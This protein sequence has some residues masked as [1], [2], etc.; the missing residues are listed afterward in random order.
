VRISVST[1]AGQYEANMRA[2]GAELTRSVRATMREVR[3]VAMERARWWSDG[4]YEQWQLTRKGHPYARRN[5][6]VV[7][8]YSQKT[9]RLS[10]RMK[11]AGRIGT[12][13]PARINYQSGDFYAGWRFHQRFTANE[14]TGSL[15]NVSPHARYLTGRPVGHM[16]GRPVMKAI[17]KDVRKRTKGLWGKC[18]RTSLRAKASGMSGIGGNFQR[19]Y[20][21]G[22]RDAYRRGYDRADRANE[23]TQ[24]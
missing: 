3:E 1:N 5:A 2:K 22:L 12:G 4:P 8:S 6:S 7:M 11:Y 13:F 23:E 17:A 10:T 20:V 19:G 21:R 15:T 18:L 9:G 24:R 14:L 16:V